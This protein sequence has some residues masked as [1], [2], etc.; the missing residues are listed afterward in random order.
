LK[1]QIAA[2]R[3]G[4]APP[5]DATN[6]LDVG[7]CA[8]TTPPTPDFVGNTWMFPVYPLTPNGVDLQNPRMP[9]MSTGRIPLPEDCRAA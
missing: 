3:D 1:E 2:G 7:E 8:D 4:D 9:P 6:H 5:T